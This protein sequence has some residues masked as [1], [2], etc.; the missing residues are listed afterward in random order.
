[1]PPIINLVTG[2]MAAMVVGLVARA[3]VLLGSTSTLQGYVIYANSKAKKPDKNFTATD[4][5]NAVHDYRIS[6]LANAAVVGVATLLL[7]WALRSTR[8]ASAS[9]WALLVVFLYTGMPFYIVPTQHLPGIAQ[10]LGVFIGVC[11]IAAVLLIFI[12]KPSQQY[13]RDCRDANLPPEARG[14]QRPGL[15]SLFGPRRAQQGATNTTRP[16][17]KPAQTRPAP[18]AP[19]AKAKV[20]SDSDAVAK[21]ADLARSRAKASKSRRTAP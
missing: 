10:V 5:A 11:A 15:G 8:T 6:G 19:K 14:K 18:A 9:R 20:R 17:T 12:P 21:G 4:V 7:I 16:P 1:V 3:L 2:V 13:F